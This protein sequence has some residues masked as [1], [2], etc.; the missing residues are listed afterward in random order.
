MRDGQTK[1]KTPPAVQVG[2]ETGWNPEAA[3]GG[4]GKILFGGWDE[5]QH[6][7]PGG[8]IRHRL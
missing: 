8:G 4:R 1:Q 5:R 2:D 7:S 6:H 3:T